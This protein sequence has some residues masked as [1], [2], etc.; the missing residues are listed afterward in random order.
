ME[1]R[2]DGRRALVTGANSGI[3]RAIVRAYVAAGAKVAINYVAHPGMA[4]EL[5][6]ELTANGGD[7]MAY[8]AD[9]SDPEAVST[10][11][12]ALDDRWGGIDILVN[13]AGIDGPR[14]LAWE[15]R[16]SAWRRVIETNLLGAFY[17]S[18]EALRRMVPARSGVVIN[19]TSVHENLPWSGYSAYS[20]SKAGLAMLTRTLAQEAGRYGVRVLSLAPGA[21]RSPISRSVQENK[22]RFE[23]LLSRIPTEDLGE[24]DDV[25][26]LAVVMSSDVARYITGT[27]VYVDGGLSLFPEYMQ[28]D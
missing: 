28:W 23:E 15:A 12:A 5:V 9:I 11:Y 21:I 6:D 22:S 7:A 18:Q 13:S 19:L 24:P 4:R 2:L 25:A 20:A 1:I 8:E 14:E 26:S 3:G 16:V 10:M 27:T 17:C